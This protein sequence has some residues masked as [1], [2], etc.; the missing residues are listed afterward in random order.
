VQISYESVTQW[1]TGDEEVRGYLARVGFV[2]MTMF[3]ILQITIENARN[4]CEGLD[5]LR[6]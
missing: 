3:G 2:R 1:P 4:D 5:K 6:L